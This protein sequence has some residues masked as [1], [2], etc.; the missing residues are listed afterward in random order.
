MEALRYYCKNRKGSQCVEN[1]AL[2]ITYAVKIDHLKNE[3]SNSLK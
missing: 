3:L 1:V 2:I